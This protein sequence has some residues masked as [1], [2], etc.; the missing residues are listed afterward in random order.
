MN[1]AHYRVP[2]LL[3]S[4]AVLTSVVLIALDATLV[5]DNSGPLRGDLRALSSTLIIVSA[6]WLAAAA[7]R[8]WLVRHVERRVE[9]VTV[10]LHQLG[11]D[12]A[13]VKENTG[14]IRPMFIQVPAR[15]VAPVH[16][17]GHGLDP[18]V[19][20]MGDRISR[21]LNEK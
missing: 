21:R 5:P 6:V 10:G 3:A 15:G 19:L 16:P 1:S 9:L 12:V 2:A 8:V 11:A 7:Q 18:A 14:D 17:N 20:D 13:F 4:V